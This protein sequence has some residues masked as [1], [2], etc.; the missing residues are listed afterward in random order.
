MSGKD[1]ANKF[2]CESCGEGHIW[3][4]LSIWD[5]NTPRGWELV[6]V[7][8]AWYMADE[9]KAY[10]PECKHTITIEEETN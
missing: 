1:G 7:K 8:K 5:N 2:T 4:K 3:I 6:K 10:C 9:Y